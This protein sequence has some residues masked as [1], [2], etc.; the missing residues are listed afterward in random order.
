MRV[1][2]WTFSDIIWL[3]LAQATRLCTGR[4]NMI[5]TNNCNLNSRRVKKKLAVDLRTSKYTQQRGY[6]RLDCVL[7]DVE[8]R[9][10]GEI[11]WFGLWTRKIQ[12]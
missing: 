4:Y 6:G 1:V 10:V 9:A 2:E 3:G 12:T 7:V 8:F 5:K 11:T